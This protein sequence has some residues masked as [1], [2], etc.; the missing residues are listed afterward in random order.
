MGNKVKNYRLTFTIDEMFELERLMAQAKYVSEVDAKEAKEANNETM[1]A[2]YQRMA[3]YAD[4]MQRTI[5]NKL[6]I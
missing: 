5:T 2:M 1:R 4:S 6:G 3:D